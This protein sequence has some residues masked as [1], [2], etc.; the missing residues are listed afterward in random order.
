VTVPQ[1]GNNN[2]DTY[3]VVK[4]TFVKYLEEGSQI[5]RITINGANCN[6]DK[7]DLKCTLN[8]G[9]ELTTMDKEQG[10]VPVV[11]DLHGRRFSVPSVSSLNAVLPKGI[12]IVN[13]K[14]VYVK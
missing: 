10:K 3:K 11:Y 1:T 9:I 13:G 7:L 14:K 4:G 5:L 8:T 12:Y 6:I 2:W